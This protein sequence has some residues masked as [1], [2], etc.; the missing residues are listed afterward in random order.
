MLVKKIMFAYESWGH[1]NSR[2]GLI[3]V[4][5][6]FIPVILDGTCSQHLRHENLMKNGSINDNT[7]NKRQ[8]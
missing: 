8:I 7:D 3:T 6:K 1:V 5:A 2:K 4:N